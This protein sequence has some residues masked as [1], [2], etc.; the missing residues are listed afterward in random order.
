[1]QWDDDQPKPKV[2]TRVGE[3]LDH[4]AL[5]DLEARILTLEGEIARTRQEIERKRKH[6]AAA[7]GLFK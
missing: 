3:P 5:A 1:M 6:Q 4:L 7:A 2:E